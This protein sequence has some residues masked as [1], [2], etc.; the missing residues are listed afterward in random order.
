MAG[1][2]QAGAGASDRRRP[3]THERDQTRALLK[4][5]ALPQFRLQLAGPRATD[6]I[7][8]P[9]LCLQFRLA[10]PG[11]FQVSGRVGKHVHQT[12]DD[13]AIFHRFAFAPSRAGRVP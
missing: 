9:R 3:A 11:E 7:G 12:P 4:A 5:A 8:V 13:N 10:E 2:H 6:E 1:G